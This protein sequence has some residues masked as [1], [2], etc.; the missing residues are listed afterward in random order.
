[1]K[2]TCERCK[3]TFESDDV[4]THACREGNVRQILLIITE[5][6]HWRAGDPIPSKIHLDMDMETG[7]FTLTGRSRKIF[8]T[9]F[10]VDLGNEICLGKYSLPARIAIKEALDA[11]L[12]D[13]DEHP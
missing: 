2:S 12:G 6:E 3:D 1:M 4:P 5:P 8:E 10:A 13:P 9:T 11:V 7:C